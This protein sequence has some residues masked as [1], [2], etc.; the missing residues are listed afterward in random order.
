M[1]LALRSLSTSSLT[2]FHRSSLIFFFIFCDTNLA[3]GQMACLWKI[4]L[5]LILGMSDD[6][7]ANK[8]MFLCRTSAMCL[9][10]W[11][12]RSLLS[13]VHCSSLGPSCNLTSSSIGFGSLSEV[14]PHGSTSNSSS[15]L[16]W[17]TVR[18]RTRDPL[19]ML[20]TWV[21]STIVGCG[22]ADSLVRRKGATFKLST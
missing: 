11:L 12:V 21:P 5:G 10:S 7:Q 18:A 13:C 6:C 3:L 19:S 9:S 17:Q 22:L 1:K 8:S 2:A 20:M 4:M 14:L 15:N 16:A